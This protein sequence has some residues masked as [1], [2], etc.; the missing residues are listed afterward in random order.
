MNRVL[1]KVIIS[2]LIL[3]G[4]AAA[5]DARQNRDSINIVNLFSAFGNLPSEMIHLESD[6]DYPFEYLSKESSVRFIE[7]GG[8]IRAII[9]HL[10][11]IK[12]YSEEPLEIARASLIAVP[13]YESDGMEQ[14]SNLD[15]ITHQPDGSAVRLD[16]S[17][18]SRSELNSR[19]TIMEFEM[20]DAKAGSILEYKY[21]V[22]RRY[23]E[24]LPD[25]YFAHRVPTR[26]AS[27][28]V[29]N[30]RFLRYEAVVE[31]ADFDVKYVR[32]EV[33]TSS[34][35]LVFSYS[36][37]EPILLERW[38]AE[39]I[40]PV[41]QTTYVS[42]VDDLRGKVRFIISEF[43]IPRQPLGNSWELVA[44]QIR[45]NA[46]PEEV[47]ADQAELKE[48]GLE[49]SGYF[50]DEV[51]AQ[52]SIFFY[53]NGRALFNNMNAVFADDGIVHVL[54][55]EPAN[56]AEINMTLLAMLRGAGIESYPLYVSGRDFG[57]INRSFPSL[58]QFNRMLV[59]SRINGRSYIMDA[60]F[61]F[62]EP[63]LIPIESYNEQGFI[64]RED[65]FEWIELTPEKSVFDLT[66]ELDLELSEQ[67][68]IMGSLRSA[69]RGYPAQRILENL[70][71]GRSAS[72]VAASTFLDAYG[73]AVI[74]NVKITT[75]NTLQS[76][77]E[78]SVDIDFEIENYANSFSD[79]IEYRPMVVGY[80]FQNPFE[81]T[82]RR[83][84]I[85]LD[86]PEHL[87]INYRLRLPEGFGVESTG[88]SMQTRIAG[89]ELVERYDSD[90]SI[91]NYSFEIDI[92]RKEFS[93]G[94][95]P[96]LRRIYERWVELSN[97]TWLIENQAP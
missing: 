24:E 69:T 48:S 26:S 43:G 4:A 12:V 5:S 57:R 51:M 83:V 40:P 50:D 23:I 85:T 49:I 38:S 34:V 75:L 93:I 68:H 55:G 88:G 22:N 73:G 78:V 65:S 18:V 28:T 6:H 97:S 58:Y 54:E 15:G 56:Q 47:I 95:Y 64:L 10:V 77:R 90:G 60:S 31:D 44:A 11:R 52:D 39:D 63:D 81:T 46:N 41:E 67:G 16:K 27:V 74:Q 14:V 70:Q 91:L 35:P 19:Y 94:M 25:F 9:D 79:G 86:A 80:L 42:S 7:D 3:A 72:G 61:P 33:D 92:S 8:G 96:E 20:P 21:T 29:Q 62:S 2:M 89:A 1:K 53:V 13:Y 66:L 36:R 59:Q 82:R 76:G 32:E 30:E 87:K 45:K 17:T 37:P 84:P 71:K